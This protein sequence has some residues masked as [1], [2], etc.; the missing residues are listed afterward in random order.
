MSPETPTEL[1]GTE[2]LADD[3]KRPY[4]DEEWDYRF[5]FI[6]SFNVRLAD[7]EAVLLRRVYVQFHLVQIRRNLQD[8]ISRR[9]S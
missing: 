8:Q 9:V 6:E 1:L 2:E 5:P 4:T 3:L 7:F